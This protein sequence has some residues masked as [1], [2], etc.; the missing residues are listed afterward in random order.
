[1]YDLVIANTGNILLL[2]VCGLTVKHLK[3]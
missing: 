2:V 1:L 3:L